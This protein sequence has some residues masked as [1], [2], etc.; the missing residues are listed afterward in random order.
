MYPFLEAVPLV[1]GYGVLVILGGL[2][3]FGGS[4][5]CSIIFSCRLAEHRQ[6]HS[7]HGEIWVKLERKCWKK[8]RTGKWMSW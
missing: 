8:V 3:D 6:G 2:D 7:L 4:R 1:S 5:M